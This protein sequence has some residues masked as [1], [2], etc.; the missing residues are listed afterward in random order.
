M[1]RGNGTDQN[2]AKLLIPDL[3]RATD[4]EWYLTAAKRCSSAAGARPTSAIHGVGMGNTGHKSKTSVPGHAQRWRWPMI[5][6]GAVLF[7]LVDSTKMAISAILGSFT[8][9]LKRSG[10]RLRNRS[11]TARDSYVQR[12]V[13]SILRSAQK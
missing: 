9:V 6:I 2:G 11:V 7:S 1:I 3:H 4:T 10:K 5:A 8:S 13:A 12:S